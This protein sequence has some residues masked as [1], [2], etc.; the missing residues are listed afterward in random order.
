MSKSNII[1]SLFIFF[2]FLLFFGLYHSIFIYDFYVIDDHNLISMLNEDGDFNLYDLKFY[3]NDWYLKY[4]NLNFRFN[5]YQIWLGIELLLFENNVSLYYLNRF[6]III[7]FLIILFFYSSRF[8]GN[9]L[10][11]LLI[12]IFISSR[13]LGDIATRIFS[14]EIITIFSIIILIPL[15]FKMI[16]ILQNQKNLIRFSTIETIIYFT[17]FN[18]LILSKENNIVFIIIPILFI[19]L[20]SK[21]KA[22]SIFFLVVNIL[23]IFLSLVYCIYIYLL[24]NKNI[25]IYSTGILS[26]L[27]NFDFFTY[28]KLVYKFLRYILFYYFG[29]IAILIFIFLKFNKNLN[30][31]NLFFIIFFSTSIIFFQFVIYSS[32]LPSNIRYDFTLELMFYLNSVLLIIYLKKKKFLIRGYDI[33]NFFIIFLLIFSLIKIPNLNIIYNNTEQ[34]KVNIIN[35]N[36]ILNEIK[37][38]SK[39]HPNFEI[40]VKSTNVW[41]Y[42]LV[43]SIYKFLNYEKVDNKKFLNI[44]NIE[45]RNLDESDK[46]F[47]QRLADVSAQN[48]KLKTWSNNSN[49][50]WGYNKLS[51]QSNTK[52]CIEIYLYGPVIQMQKKTRFDKYCKY[53][54]NYFFPSKTNDL[55]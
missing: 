24:I 17:S 31:K 42:E 51:D 15:I 35:F 52:N 19:Y 5:F 22:D 33:L 14:S 10:S 4:K 53:S 39:S 3:I 21:R 49:L 1:K 2:I 27:L 8:I 43:S 44:D 37:I 54:I 6:L 34:K 18:I 47:Y 30:V 48:E 38:L 50:Q 45:T 7:T 9:Y 23:I 11:F 55:L 40:I 26:G 25:E 36:T 32:N 20:Y 13:S 28:L 46:L 41:D 16:G 29:H 12:F